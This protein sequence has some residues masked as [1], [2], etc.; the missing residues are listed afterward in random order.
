MKKKIKL[1]LL[2]KKSCLTVCALYRVGK[3]RLIYFH[4]ENLLNFKLC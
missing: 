2:Q 3:K 4:Y 1:V